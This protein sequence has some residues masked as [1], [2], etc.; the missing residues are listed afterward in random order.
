[1]SALLLVAKAAQRAVAASGCDAEVSKGARPLEARFTT[2]IGGYVSTPA[3]R[4]AC[5]SFKGDSP[6]VFNFQQL[7]LLW[8]HSCHF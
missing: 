8:E 1:M 7:L 6:V 3:E 4:N 2:F 5:I